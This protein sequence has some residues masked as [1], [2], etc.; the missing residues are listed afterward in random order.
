M[1]LTRVTLPAV[2]AALL[3]FGPAATAA[4]PSRA[5]AKRALSH[6]TQLQHGKG[7]KTGRELTPAL[8]QLFAALPQL[9]ADDRASARAILARPG[10]PGPDPSGANS[11]SGPE[12]VDSPKCTTHFCVHYAAVGSDSSNAA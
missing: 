11:W 3:A 1:K 7:V 4:P 6:A 2:V 5:D 8:Q 12:A 10:D 9:S